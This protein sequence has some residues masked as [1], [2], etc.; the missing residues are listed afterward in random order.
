MSCEQ[1]VLNL[2]GVL[3]LAAIMRPRK[4]YA[5]SGD[6]R[7]G[8][9][10]RHVGRMPKALMHLASLLGIWLSASSSSGLSWF[11]IRCLRC[12]ALVH[13]LHAS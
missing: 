13:R 8:G 1:F 3:T 12:C 11:E 4:R 5:G 9:R 7:V 10:T 6:G 2:K